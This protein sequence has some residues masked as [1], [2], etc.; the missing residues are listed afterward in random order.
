MCGSGV[1]A[2]T[3]NKGLEGAIGDSDQRPVAVTWSQLRAWVDSLPPDLA[4]EARAIRT[5]WGAICH[6][7]TA[8]SWAEKYATYGPLTQQASNDIDCDR[9]E[10]LVNDRDRALTQRC[11]AL[12][13]EPTD[14]LELLALGGAA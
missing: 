6:Q 3:T 13:N 2:D 14:L 11:E 4:I 12:V 10:H 7:R 1:H 9:R 8:S 5:E